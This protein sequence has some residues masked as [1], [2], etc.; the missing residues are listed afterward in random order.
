[1]RAVRFGSIRKRKMSADGECFRGAI[2]PH[3][4]LFPDDAAPIYGQ[5]K[6]DER[7]NKV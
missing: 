2:R 3:N 7:P 4:A 1:M 6:A 5:N